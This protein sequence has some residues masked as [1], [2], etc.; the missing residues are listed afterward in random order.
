[1]LWDR[2]D[3][4]VLAALSIVGAVIVAWATIASS[5]TDD[6]EGQVTWLNVAVVGLLI[7]A[8]SD[9]AWLIA[10][11]RRIL[12]ARRSLLTSPSEEPV[13]ATPVDASSADW[14]HLSGTVRAHRPSCLLI[15]G[16][17]AEP[18][19]AATA[20]SLGVR[21]CEICGPGAGS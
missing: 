7:A 1:M 5:G 12:E 11:R 10:G 3:I 17:P 2:R 8:G 21:R 20:R 16:K 9:V 6:L 14:V 19:D 18:I 15:D 13:S 4:R